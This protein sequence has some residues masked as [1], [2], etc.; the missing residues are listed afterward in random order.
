MKIKYIA[1]D[2]RAGAI[3]Y[4]VFRVAQPAGYIF[5]FHL[6]WIEWRRDSYFYYFRRSGIIVLCV[7]VFAGAV[8]RFPA[9]RLNARVGGCVWPIIIKL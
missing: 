4:N 7:C 1:A 2:L 5:R 8:F 6:S 9:S 3:E